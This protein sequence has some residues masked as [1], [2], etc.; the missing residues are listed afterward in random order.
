[1]TSHKNPSVRDLTIKFRVQKG[2]VSTEPE[3]SNTAPTIL[4][5]GQALQRA[6]NRVPQA[7]ERPPN[8]CKRHQMTTAEKKLA[9]Y[10]LKLASQE[11]SNH[12]CN[13]LDLVI[14]VGLTPEESL[15]IRKAAREANGDLLSPEEKPEDHWAADW[16]MMSW[17][18]R[19][20]QA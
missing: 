18:A 4:A 8:W 11:F 10:L 16:A 3:P 17:M 19:R 1:M 13:D 7:R 15:A 20:L 2:R 6:P 9:A 14:E 5:N 12:G